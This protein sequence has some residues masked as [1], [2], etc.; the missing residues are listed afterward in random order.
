M[1]ARGAKHLGELSDMV[2]DGHRA[3]MFY[4]VQRDDADHMKLAADIDPAYSKAF[5]KAHKAGVEALAYCCKLGVEGI[6]LDR[7]IEF[8]TP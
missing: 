3:V 6:E 1:T 8:T 5:T 2:K 7:R 4:L